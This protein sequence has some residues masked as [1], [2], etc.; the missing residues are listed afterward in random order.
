MPGIIRSNEHPSHPQ[1]VPFNFEDLAQR[2][3]GYLDTVRADAAR[4]LALAAQQAEELKRQAVE[5][6]RQ[7]ASAEA[8]QHAERLLARQ[9]DTLLPALRA[10]MDAISTTRHEWLAEWDRRVVRL[11]AAM[12]ARILRRELTRPP[13]LAPTLVREALEMITDTGSVRV[14]LHPQDLQTLGEQS[15]RLSAE[16][17]RLGTLEFLPDP[18]L[19]PGGCRVETRFGLIDQQIESQLARLAEELA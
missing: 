18:Q 5:Q 4:L 8:R 17:A 1:P 14:Y 15:Q 13:S 12:A 2:A 11:A 3:Q 19:T 6:G 7:Q 10:A 9:L 16:F